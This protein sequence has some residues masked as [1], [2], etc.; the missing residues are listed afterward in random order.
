[1]LGQKVSVRVMV[2]QMNQRNA[3]VHVNL[4]ALTRSVG[5][6]LFFIGLSNSASYF[7]QC[8]NKIC[9]GVT[10]RSVSSIIWT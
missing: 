8:K 9:E 1:M 6:F 2:M 7:W 4:C 10:G 3:L 5:K